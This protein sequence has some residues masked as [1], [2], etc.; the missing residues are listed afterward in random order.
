MQSRDWMALTIR[1][2]DHDQALRAATIIVQAYIEPPW[3]EEWSIDKATDRICEL[4]TTPGWLGVGAL[5]EGELRGFAIGIPHTTAAGRAL[6]IHEIA[7]LP[8][9]QRR[10]IGTSLLKLLEKEAQ[11]SGFAHA[12]LVSRNEGA[13]ADYYK[14]NG[15]R[16]IPHLRVYSRSIR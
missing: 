8:S 3:N 7:V 12:L 16:Q 11:N 14:C 9:H 4:S 2:I 13:V 5:E 6:Y 1:R 15:Y 10:G